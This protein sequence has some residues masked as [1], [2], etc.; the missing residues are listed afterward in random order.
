MKCFFRIL[1]TLI[2]VD[3]LNKRNCRLHVGFHEIKTWQLY[4]EKTSSKF[5]QNPTGDEPSINR[6]PSLTEVNEPKM[7]ADSYKKR[8]YT[9]YIP[10]TVVLFHYAQV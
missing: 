8:S 7:N 5:H 4:L 1:I 9:M 2:S 6:M 10:P 3:S